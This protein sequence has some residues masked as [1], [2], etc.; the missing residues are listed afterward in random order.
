MTTLWL[1]LLVAVPVALLATGSMLLMGRRR[2][3]KAGNDRTASLT[4]ARRAVRAMGREHH[5]QRR[6]TIRGT[7]GGGPGTDAGVGSD[8]MGA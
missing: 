5:R 7:G 2:S 3:V 4:E 8:G 6:G 1:T